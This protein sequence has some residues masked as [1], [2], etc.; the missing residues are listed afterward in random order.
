MTHSTHLS[1]EESSQLRA[2][3]T[4][5]GV[6]MSEYI[7]QA[8]RTR[9]KRDVDFTPAEQNVWEQINTIGAKRALEVL[10]KTSADLSTTI[11]T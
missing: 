8:I 9:L 11:R 4:E 10:T 3:V 1:T 6:S 7:A 5:R 2:V